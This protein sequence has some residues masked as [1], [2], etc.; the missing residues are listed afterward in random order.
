MVPAWVPSSASTRT[1]ASCGSWGD[2]AYKLKRAVH[3]DYVDFST[4]ELRRLACEAEVRLNRRTA[5]SLYRGVVPVTRERDGSI[6]LAKSID[7]LRKGQLAVR[8]AAQA[9]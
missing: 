9:R 6:A 8:D 3:F 2:R 1:S 7:H 5:P 4:V